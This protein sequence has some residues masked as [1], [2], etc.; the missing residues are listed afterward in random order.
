MIHKCY[1]KTLNRMSAHLTVDQLNQE[2]NVMY[3]VSNGEG[4]PQSNL[5]PEGAGSWGHNQAS[6]QD[7]RYPAQQ[8]NSKTIDLTRPDSPSG[9][10]ITGKDQVK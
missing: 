9:P 4:S 1:E 10:Q 7:S 3:N 5:R 8:G 6:G 2:L